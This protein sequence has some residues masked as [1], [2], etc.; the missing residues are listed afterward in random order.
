MYIVGM[1][2][3]D[4]LGLVPKHGTMAELGVKRGFNARRM[5]GTMKPTAMHLI[6]P[7]A[8]DVDPN[9]P[10][11]AAREV[12]AEF[13]EYYRQTLEWAA[14]EEAEGKVTVTRDYAVSAAREFPDG[15]FDFIYVDTMDNYDD[16]FADLSAYAKKMKKSGIIAV[17]DYYDIMYSPAKMTIRKPLPQTKA[18]GNILAANDFCD[19]FGWEIL[20]IT[21]EYKSSKR[22]PKLFAGRAGA[23][24]DAHRLLDRVLQVTPW[25]VEVDD[26]RR[27]RQSMFAPE[28]SDKRE[29]RRFFTRIV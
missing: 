21:D 6:D 17:D 22:P 28:G 1:D 11:P 4:I 12:R 19:M 27:V 26:P 23:N 29:D 7:W 14:S 25:A 5:F 10:D 20:F 16:Q 13:D 3:Q 8:M 24:G 18:L 15:Y 2:F 9:D